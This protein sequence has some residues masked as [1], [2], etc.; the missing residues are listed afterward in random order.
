MHATNAGEEPAG[1][2][3]PRGSHRKFWYGIVAIVVLAALL[4]G[5]HLH[6]Y[7]QTP[8][9]E[10]ILGDGTAYDNWAQDVAAGNWWGDEVFY[11][12]PLYPY[13]LATVYSVCGH[14]GMAVRIVQVAFGV[15]ACVFL[16]LAARRLFGARAGLIA[17]LLLAIYPPAIFFD[18][19]LQK[20]ALDTVLLCALLAVLAGARDGGLA[21]WA[22]LGAVGGLLMLTRENAS[23]L[24]GGIVVWS[25]CLRS[26]EL[27]QRAL[28]VGVLLA[29]VFLV[30]GPVALRNY[31][32][33]GEFHVTTSQLGPNFYIGNGP[34]ANGTYVPLIPGRG[35]AQ[36]ERHDARQ[37]A[38]EASGRSLAPGEVSSYWLDRAL[39]TIVSE[40][41]QWIAL[42]VRKTVFFFDRVEIIDTEDQY[43]HADTSPVLRALGRVFHFGVLF[44]LAALGAVALGRRWREVWVL[45]LLAAAYTASVLAFYVVDRYRFPVVPFFVLFAAGGLVCVPALRNHPRRLVVGAVVA[46]AAA[47]FANLSPLEPDHMRAATRLYVG[48][49]LYTRG[50]LERAE[51]W[52]REAVELQPEQPHAQWALGRV[53]AARGE[54]EAARRALEESL[55]LQPHHGGARFQLGKLLEKQGDF[56]GAREQYERA[57]RTDDQHAEAWVNLGVLEARANRTEEALRHFERAVQADPTLFPAQSNLARALLQ[58]GREADAVARLR[59]AIEAIPDSAPLLVQLAMVLATSSDAQIRDGGQALQFAERAAGLRPRDLGALEATACALAELGRFDEAVAAMESALAVARESGGRLVPRLESRLRQFR[60]GEPARDEFSR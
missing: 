36:F 4:R 47:L 45:A 14:S 7:A 52:L 2:S 29:G 41:G 17:G 39:D 50:D 13:F 59:S 55:R 19:L 32:V 30:L 33:G 43:T 38:E 34:D 26:L 24:L 20:S 23:V 57:L 12:A 21:R 10:L 44:P 56:R 54:D 28:R 58:L 27:R 5:L 8:M 31:S 42:M 11:Q 48:Q 51:P 49:A 6:A 15:A 37:L 18:V 25:F 16:A 3:A 40:P 22:L 60:A 53:L 46:L 9:F 1:E 35:D